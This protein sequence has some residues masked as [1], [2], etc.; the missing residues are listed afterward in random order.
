MI[1]NKQESL[2]TL[3]DKHLKPRVREI[4]S[5]YYPKDIVKLLGKDGYFSSKDLTLEEIVQ[6]ELQ[7]VKQASAICMTT[8]FLIWCHLASLTYIRNSENEPLK[9]RFLTRLEQGEVLAS[10]GLSNA[11]KY[12]GGLEKLHLKARE[13]EEGYIL[14]GTLP[15]VSNLSE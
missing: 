15:A 14:S 11:M 10:T 9:N 6:R 8:G 4:D 3:F 1:I 13:T 2:T 12:Y 7:V 5:G